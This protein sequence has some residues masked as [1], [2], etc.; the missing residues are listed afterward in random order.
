MLVPLILL[1]IITR[2]G[3]ENEDSKWFVFHTAM[4]NLILGVIWEFSYV[5]SNFVTQTTIVY[6]VNAIINLTVN[7]I[8]PLAFTR[9]FRLYFPFYYEK[10]FTKKTLLP[11]MLSY[12]LLILIF[13]MTEIVSQIHIISMILSSAVFLFNLVCSILIFIKIHG[14]MKLVADNAQLSTLSDLRRAAIICIFQTEVVSFNLFTTFYFHLFLTY[15]FPNVEDMG[16]LETLMYIHLAFS[17]LK[18]S[19]YQFFVIVDTCVT[20]FVLRSYRNSIKKVF[21]YT[22]SLFIKKRKITGAKIIVK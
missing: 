19:I 21:L 16:W 11:W 14:M 17:R 12:D 2:F 15:L 6:I 3:K 22:P 20:L 9:F 4:L 8:F 13:I 18:N 10:L 1:I 5:I 7:S